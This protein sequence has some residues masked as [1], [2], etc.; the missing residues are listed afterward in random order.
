M[1][2]KLTTLVFAAAAILLGAG[3]TAPA[4][5]QEGGGTP[6]DAPYGDDALI[7]GLTPS[8]WEQVGDIEHYNVAALYDKIDGRSELYMAYDVL[9]LS[10]VS[11]VDKDDSSNFIDL[12]VYDLQSPSAAFGVFSVEREPGQPKLGFGRSG[13]RTGSNYFYWKGDY[14]AYVQASKDN[15]KSRA[16]GLAVAKGL[17]PRLKDDG[18]AVKGLD[19]VPIKTLVPETIQYF[20]SDAMSLDFMSNTFTAKYMVGET[21]VTAFMTRRGSNDEAADIVKQ[22][23]GY[24][25]DYGED[26]QQKTVDGTGIALADLGGEY[27]DAVFQLD[28]VVAGVS[29]T[30]G[31]EFTEKAAKAL[32]ALL[33]AN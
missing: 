10:W 19:L 9:G 4:L 28:D 24:F 14:Y 6:P 26:I 11:F 18:S 25:A 27:Y 29:A 1:K 13:Y 21:E 7:E 15:D 30:K 32:L 31:A 5:A 17:E 3:I 2:R 8:G 22:Y 12:F 20:R 23:R 33:K 16:A